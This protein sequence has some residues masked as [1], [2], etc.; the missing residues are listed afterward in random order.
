M[1]KVKVATPTNRRAPGS[2]FRA[3]VLTFVTAQILL[4]SFP[5]FA[6][7]FHPTQSQVEAAYLYNFGKFVT[8]PADRLSNAET[9]QIC[10]LGR[11]PFGSALDSIVAGETIRGKKI[12]LQRLTTIQQAQS[13]MIL[14]VSPSEERQMPAILAAAQSFSILTVS[15]LE[16][17]AEH[18]GTI[19]LVREQDRVRFEVNRAAAE[20]DHLILSS[21]LLKVAVKIIRKP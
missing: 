12:A 3:A 4:I 14:Y 10:I 9:F 5:S 15:D 6:Q 8:W 13:C 7:D 18:G 20:Q 21:E 19:G 16:H 2:R 1:A 11:D 17:F